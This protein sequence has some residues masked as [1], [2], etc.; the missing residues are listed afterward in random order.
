MRFLNRLL[1]RNPPFANE[2]RRVLKHPLCKN[3]LM[4]NIKKMGKEMKADKWSAPVF[5]YIEELERREWP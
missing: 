4:W 3:S 2:K 1:R 5:E